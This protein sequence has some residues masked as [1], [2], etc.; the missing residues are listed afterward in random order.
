MFVVAL[1]I[2]F[3]YDRAKEVAIN[4][5][6]QQ[7]YDVEI[8]SAGPTWGAGVS[9]S[10]IRVKTRPTTGKPTRFTIEKASVTTSILGA[11]FSSAPTTTVTLDAFG[12]RIEL[13]Q[14][15]TPGNKKPFRVEVTARDVKVS[16]IPGVRETINLPLSGTLKLD[17]DLASA[18]GKFA[19]AKGEISFLCEALRRG[20]R[21]VAAQDRGQRLPGRRPDVAQGAHR[22]PARRDRRRQGHGE[23]QGHRVEVARRRD[24]ARG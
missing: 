1:Y 10:N 4:V 22:R 13:S 6:S 8:E 15:G 7:G 3:P 9:F 23:A 24:V 16:E 18:T 17:V 14:S 21:E 19:D 12:G 2:W 11:I 5:A 20:R